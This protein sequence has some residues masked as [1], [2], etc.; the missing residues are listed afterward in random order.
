MQSKEDAVVDPNQFFLNGGG[1]LRENLKRTL[2]AEDSVRPVQPSVRVDSGAKGIYCVCQDGSVFCDITTYSIRF[3]PLSL[4]AESA[5]LL[6][7]PEHS[8]KLCARPRL[9]SS[10]A[11]RISNF[12]GFRS[13][14]QTL[15]RLGFAGLHL[16]PNFT[17]FI[18][19]FTMSSPRHSYFNV[20]TGSSRAA[21]LAGYKPAS[22]LTTM[23]NAI[24]APTSHSGMIHTGSD[25]N[26]CRWR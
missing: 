18:R 22:R 17:D 2:V 16:P 6:R 4:S 3:R 5:R 13:S 9:S 25:G 1:I 14:G 19:S 21:R 11:Y 24:A 10:L 8:R 7:A 26:W 20:C 15:L 23:E 12:Q